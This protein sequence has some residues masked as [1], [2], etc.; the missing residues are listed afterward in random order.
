MDLADLLECS[1]CLE[2]L[3]HQNKVLPCQHTFCTQCLKD[4]FK[5]NQELLCP[6]CREKVVTSIDSLPPNIL[7]NRILE[8]MGHHKKATV[9]QQT[10]VSEIKSQTPILNPTKC[11]PPALPNPKKPSSA[12]NNSIQVTASH[13]SLP[14]LNQILQ[15][16]TTSPVK[17]PVSISS[18]LT[19]SPVCS[20]TLLSP[21][22]GN[23]NTNPFM[24]LIEVQKDNNLSNKMEGLNLQPHIYSASHHHVGTRLSNFHD[25]NPLSLSSVPVTPPP[26]PL[27][28]LTSSSTL[29]EA[30]SVVPPLPDRNKQSTLESTKQWQL[31]PRALIEPPKPSSV[32][33]SGSKSSAVVPLYKAVFEYKAVQ[34]DELSLRKGELFQV[35]EKCHDGWFKGKNIKTG[36]SGVFPGNYV[37]EYDG[38]HS[39]KS[40]RKESVNVNEGNLIDLSDEDQKQEKEPE[41]DAERLRKL[42]AIRET[43]RQAQQQLHH[44][45]THHHSTGSSGQTKLKADKY[46]CVVPFPSNSEYEIDLNIGDVVTLVK[47]REDGWCK[48]THHRTGKTGL[49]PASFVEKIQ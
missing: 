38:K 25:Q 16:P 14:V 22:P 9:S 18:S 2:Q 20:T 35:L 3:S 48:G 32:V 42:K 40:K 34:K 29:L 33:S 46:R 28:T 37:K 4:V 13:S 31:S 15:S 24:D 6:E 41:S 44:P 36:K 30:S 1:I 45:S 23:P 49:F 21:I 43:L 47:K 10:P 26:R 12:V 17:L 39:K 11:Q 5:K 27:S 19:S 7:A 8:S